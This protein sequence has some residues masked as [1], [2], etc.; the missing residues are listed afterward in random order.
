[1]ISGLL[2]ASAISSSARRTMSSSSDCNNSLASFIALSNSMYSLYLLTI[3]PS[4]E[5]SLFKAV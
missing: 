4:S 5:N 3:G 1:M 2:A